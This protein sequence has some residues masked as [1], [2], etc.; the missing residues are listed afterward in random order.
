[1][2][3][4]LSRP[5]STSL[6]TWAILLAVAAIAPLAAAT[7]T[8]DTV[9]QFVL[10]GET[11]FACA[12]HEVDEIVWSPLD[13]D[14]AEELWI[15]HRQGVGGACH[16][17]SGG[18]TV[19]AL[20]GPEPHLATEPVSAA[21]VMP[22][23]GAAMPECTGEPVPFCGSTDV[24]RRTSAILKIVVLDLPD[25]ACEPGVVALGGPRPVVGMIKVDVDHD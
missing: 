16:S 11:L 13:G 5:G 6:R 20:K 18:F 1:M 25:P 24:P 2:G 4:D 23:E 21:W 8:F 22:C 9:H 7:H 12:G 15:T 10:S 3:R 19:F 17:W 14:I